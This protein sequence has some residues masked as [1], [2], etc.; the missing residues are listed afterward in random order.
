MKIVI[1]ALEQ[2]GG[3]EIFPIISLVIFLIV[4]GVTIYLVLTADKGYI[5]EMKN[6]PL[7]SNDDLHSDQYQSNRNN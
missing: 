4:F 2:I 5:D 7:E 6:M 3:I 1:N